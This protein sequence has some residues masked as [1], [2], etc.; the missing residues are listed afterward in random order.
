MIAK[1][2]R[3]YRKSFSGLSRDIWLLAFITLINRSGSMVMPFL[4][5]YITT[6]LGHSLQEAGY[7]MAAFG[8]GSLLGAFL[9]GKITD[10]LGFFPVMFGSLFFGGIMFIGMMLMNTLW[11]LIPYTFLLSAVYDMFRP[12]NLVSISAYS[13]PD[14]RTRSMALVRLA[15]NLGF[16]VGPAIGGFLAFNVGYK[17]LFIADGITCILAAL[18]LLWFLKPARKN[19]ETKHVILN[20]QGLPPWRNIQFLR[21]ILFV[22]TNAIVFMQIFSTLPVY[23]KQE[24]KLTESSIGLLMGLNGILVAL[25]EMPLIYA[26]ENKQ[27][28][29]KMITA[30]ALLMSLSYPGFL[31]APKEQFMAT[32]SILFLSFGEMFSFPFCNTVAMDESP[33]GRQGEYMGWYSMSF[34]LGFILAPLIGLG[35]ADKL[36]FQSLWYFI[37]LVGLITSYGFRKSSRPTV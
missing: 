23:F 35:V 26:T 33:E 4:S 16:S 15:I 25:L 13:N 22:M 17:S 9:G 34:S 32:V 2:L 21:F 1:T 31:I 37:T 8:C 10:K 29:L 24:L 11:K 7:V 12:A 3:A 5:V 18:C 14:N 27:S 28:K 19:D 20:K 30:G 6:K 36:G